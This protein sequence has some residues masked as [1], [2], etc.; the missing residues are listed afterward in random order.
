MSGGVPSCPGSA[1][2]LLSPAGE[3]SASPG[4]VWG[5][6]RAQAGAVFLGKYQ[7][8][9]AFR[10]ALGFSSRLEIENFELATFINF[11][12]L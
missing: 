11:T 1:T 8:H 6:G 10:E 2:V 5:D 3:F 7:H 4:S 9:S 12:G